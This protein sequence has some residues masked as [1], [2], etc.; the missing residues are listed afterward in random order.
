VDDAVRIACEVADALEYA[1]QHGIVHRDIKPENILLH[2]GHAM[3]ADFGI[4]LAASRSEG[5]TRMTETG[6]SLGTPHYMS[7][8]QSMG[9]R[10]ITPKADI[11]A[12]GCVL[13]EM[14]TAEPPFTGATAQAIIA[15]VMTEEPRSLTLQRRSIPPHVEAAVERALEKLPADRFASAAEFGAAL[16]DERVPAHRRADA[17]TGRAAPFAR[18]TVLPWAVA[19]VAVVVAAV[20]LLWP[21]AEAPVARY[22]LALP[23]SQSAL[24]YPPVLSP[25]GSA[26]LFTG[27][28]PG[29][30]STT[31]VQLWLKFRDRY[32][33][34]PVPGTQDVWNATFSPD[35]RWIAYIK[36]FHL[37]KIAV[38][39]GSPVTL[40]DSAAPAQP[41]I[42][43]LD[44]GTIVF[45]QRGAL[46]LRRV[47]AAGGASTIVL[48]ASQTTFEPAQ[49]PGGRAILFGQC[50]DRNCA[51]SNLMALDL[52]S[53]AS[54]L[55]VNGAGMGRY[56][57]TGD[58]L[59]VRDDG[60]AFAAPFDL[61]ALKLKGSPAA[62]L[63]SVAVGTGPLIAVSNSGTMVVR[64]GAGA[65]GP[66]TGRFE[67]VWVDRSG[68]TTPIEMGG[69]IAIDPGGGNPGWA[70][71]PDGR[72]LA[73]GLLTSAG[74]D[75]WV[76]QL[77]S[78]P[79]SRVTFDSTVE[80][81]PRWVPGGRAIS[82][83]GGPGAGLELHQ[84]NA[85]G[86]G[87]ETVLARHPDGIYEGAISPDGR[88]IVARIRGGLGHQGR[89]IIGYHRGDTT[90][91]PLIASVA[92]DENA[93]RLSP[94]GRWIAYESDESGRR[95]VYVRPFPNTDA[96]K[97]Q[98]STEGG[99]APLWAPNGRELF[100]VDAQRR[101][102]AVSFTAGAQPRL[103]DR[104]VLFGFPESLY[105][106]END[107]YTPFDISPD[108]QRFIMARQIQTSGSREEPFIVVENWFTE[109]KRLR[110]R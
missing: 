85:D 86:T 78:G 26:L 97:W 96:G 77:P 37:M 106:W 19:G 104:R 50:S 55:V 9:E 1:H 80:I 16:K 7:P 103:G 100:F 22:G 53:G 4:A 5:G 88:W 76:K 95:E 41:G 58:L 93:F 15:R 102:T 60:A 25:D 3:V 46:G 21:R 82:F 61:G 20:A 92:F 66:I 87:G 51:V 10:E 54:H 11:Y 34:V 83:V 27:Q 110:Q 39:G 44:D 71:S 17:R 42:A 91:V 12:L 30:S 108:G 33:A 48:R 107:Y 101:M 57:P 47:S 72:R 32:D 98:A 69:P 63:D 23:A 18:T 28:V 52:R 14:L 81:R 90:A 109:L 45:V 89:D 74:G 79:V 105:L 68:R 2:G 40:A 73:I 70:L 13:Y 75:I 29:Q 8:E 35:G 38:S 43:W 94:D 64:R 62:I 56:L 67:M 6:M 49:L 24:P 99:F 65:Q 59:Y 84:V 36:D 31:F